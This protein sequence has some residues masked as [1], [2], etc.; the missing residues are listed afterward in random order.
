MIILTLASLVQILDTHAGWGALRDRLNAPPPASETSMLK[1]SFWKSATEHYSSIVVA[2]AQNSPK[3]WKTFG[4]FAAEN[5]MATNAVYLAR[6]DEKKL[7]LMQSALINGQ[8]KPSNL[9]IIEDQFIPYMLSS[10]D[11]KNDLLTKVDGFNVLAPK[12][13]DCNQCGQNH[14]LFNLDPFIN[15]THLN[16]QIIFTKNAGLD[17]RYLLNG[18]SNFIEDWGVWSERSESQ[19]ILPIPRQ[20]KAQGVTLKLRALVNSTHPKQTIKIYI[21]GNWYADAQLTSFD[22]NIVNINLP[23]IALE[24]GY[25]AIK[26]IYSNAI[27]PRQLG[28]GSDSRLLD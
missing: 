4:L 11:F 3:H 8:I 14:E 23:K 7:R 13:K 10:L 24:Q 19:L 15:P 25:V 20:G 1:S 6:I 9:Y 16:Q 21:N 5:H 12:W 26:L 18:W 27:S 17:K 22:D 2:P 28:S